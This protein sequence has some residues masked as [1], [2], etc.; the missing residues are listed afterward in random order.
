M[1]GNKIRRDLHGDAQSL[2]RSLR[3]SGSFQRHRSPEVG[4]VKAMHLNRHVRGVFESFLI[5]AQLEKCA[6]EEK[7]R[8]QISRLEIEDLT[9]A[10]FGI[11]RLTKPQ[12]QLCELRKH[13]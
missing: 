2:C 5:T 13:G 12:M 3:I 4:F 1:C 8:S 6:C 7:L 9:Q 11:F 10:L